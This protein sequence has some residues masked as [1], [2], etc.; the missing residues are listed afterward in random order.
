[1]FKVLNPT[2]IIISSA[3]LKHYFA[4][5]HYCVIV[6]NESCDKQD[7]SLLLSSRQVLLSGKSSAVEKHCYT[8]L[9]KVQYAVVV[10]ATYG[11]VIYKL[12]KRDILALTVMM[13]Q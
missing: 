4:Y 2:T 3:L 1:M 8:T 7:I 9:E 11:P 12:W 5:K 6:A 10:H 13:G